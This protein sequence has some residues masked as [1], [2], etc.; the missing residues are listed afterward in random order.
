MFV[1][2]KVL[3]NAQLN[4]D[5]VYIGLDKEGHSVKTDC[6]VTGVIGGT[7]KYT[8]GVIKASIELSN[9]IHSR[10]ATILN[11]AYLYSKKFWPQKQHGAIIPSK[12]IDYLADI[13]S[14]EDDVLTSN[15]LK[16]VVH[17]I[18]KKYSQNNC[19][20]EFIVEKPLICE[21]LFHD[22]DPL[23]NPDEIK[24]SCHKAYIGGTPDLII[25]ALESEATLY[26]DDDLDSDPCV[27]TSYTVVDFK[28]VTQDKFANWQMQM[29]IYSRMFSAWLKA[30][31]IFCSPSSLFICNSVESKPRDVS[32]WGLQNEYNMKQ[33]FRDLYLSKYNLEIS[34]VPEDIKKCLPDIL[35]LKQKIKDIEDK[36]KLELDP[37]KQE[38]S[39]K[40]SQLIE[41]LNNVGEDKLPFYCRDADFTL[42]RYGKYR[43]ALDFKMLEDSDCFR[44]TTFHG[45]AHKIIANGGVVLF[46]EAPHCNKNCSDS[47]E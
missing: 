20:L 11:E 9:A 40:I 41:K 10:I 44:K 23:S 35:D 6:S 21:F 8:N 15:L 34:T 19:F 29:Y 18:N 36:Q 38:L 42:V 37:L 14:K 39:S 5:H 22:K 24:D 47:A 46:N 45:Y 32:V 31:G 2:N 1:I 4:E 33:K 16:Q 17:I 28:N 30:Q 12:I 7:S 3:G 13:I 26:K 25:V 43:T 27:P